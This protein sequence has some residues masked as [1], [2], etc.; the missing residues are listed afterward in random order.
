MTARMIIPLSLLIAFLA[1]GCGAPSAERP[2]RKVPTARPPA[3]YTVGK[4]LIGAP[5]GA[6]VALA[7]APVTPLAGWLTP[8]VVPSPDGRYVAYNAW[9][10]LR[11]DD[12]ALS[13]ADQGIARGD[14]LAR[15]SIR[16]HNV[17]AG[18]DDVFA[19]GAFSLAWRSDGA[20]AYFQGDEPEY[21]AGVPY[22][23]QIVVRESLGA[24]AQAWTTQSARYVVAGWAGSTLLAYEEQEGEA[25]DVLALDGPGRIRTL[26]RD[27][28]LVAISP[29]GRE[30]LVERGPESG[31]PTVRTIAVATG[32]VRAA[33][34]LTSV[35]PAVGVAGYSGDWQGDLA[36]ASSS[37]GLA[38]FRI[39]DGRIGLEQAISVAG[40][41]V[42]EPRF[43]AD[44]DRL[45]GWVTTPGGGA[46]L[47]CDRASGTCQRVVPLPTARGVRGFSAWRRPAY[48][49]SRP[50]EGER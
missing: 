34:D 1:A 16:L 26:A 27:S 22:R 25:L 14:P 13:W 10:A 15:P 39:G 18:T 44:G 30:A 32:A 4:S 5:G 20:V 21:R 50:Q 41:G 49:P 17:A 43:A 9:Q 40:E 3:V 8:A 2:A 37:S 36:V 46:F 28:G 35:D 38:V 31:P 33:L 48:N 19:D 47:D 23:G 6:R 24:P 29:D 11:E 12:P 7:A 45:T 42:A